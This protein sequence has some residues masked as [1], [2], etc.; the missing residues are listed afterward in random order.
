MFKKYIDSN[1]KITFVFFI[2][3]SNLFCFDKLVGIMVDFIPDNDPQTSGDGTFLNEVDLG[4]INYD[5]IEKCSSD[6]F[7][8]DKPP[9][10]SDYFLLQMKAVK[11]YYNSVSNG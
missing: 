8:V 3:I 6:N 2:L 11:N 9:H 10:N 4:F 7:L 5:N 1:C